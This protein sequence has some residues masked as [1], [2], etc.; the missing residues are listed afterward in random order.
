MNNI[1]SNY[2]FDASEKSITFTGNETLKIEGLKLITHI[3]SG[4]IIY[5]FNDAVNGGTL[6]NNVLTLDYNTT[7]FSDTDKLQIIYDSPSRFALSAASEE[8]LGFLKSLLHILKPLQIV[9]GAGSNR[10]SV[11]VNSVTG[12]IGT[13]TTVTGVTTV[14]TVSSVTNIANIGNVNAFQ[15]LKDLSLNTFANSV[16]SKIT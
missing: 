4:T 13:V 12:T 10:L 2:I 15:M 6:S 11:D 16:R 3:P 9:T 7:T 5:R 14:T 1:L 8:T